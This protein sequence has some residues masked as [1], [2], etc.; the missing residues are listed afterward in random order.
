M[1]QEMGLEEIERIEE[2]FHQTH[3]IKYGYASKA[4]IEL[5]NI[6]LRVEAERLK[7]KL[8]RIKQKMPIFKRKRSCLFEGEFYET[9]ILKGRASNFQ[10]VGPLI[11]EDATATVVVPPSHSVKIDEFG[12][13]HLKRG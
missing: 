9:P 3:R 13:I 11:I 10:Q 2:Q 7:L 8:P 6:R 4:P 1:T 5:V 12:I